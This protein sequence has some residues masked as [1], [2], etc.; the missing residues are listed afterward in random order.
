MTLEQFDSMVSSSVPMGHRGQPE[1]IA[2]TVVFL[3]S[4]AQLHR[5]QSFAIDGGLTANSGGFMSTFVLVHGSW[6]DGSVASTTDLR[7][8]HLALLPRSPDMVKA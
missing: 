5:G 1:E 7:K 8:G 6:H 3:C 2:A 4:D